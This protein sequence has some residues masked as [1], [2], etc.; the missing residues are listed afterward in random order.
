[1]SFLTIAQ[2]V[3]DIL[4]ADFVV[5]STYIENRTKVWQLFFARANDLDPTDEAAIF[6]PNKWNNEWTVLLAYSVSYDIYVRILSGKFL[7]ISNTS[8]EVDE[9]TGESN[10]TGNIKKIVTGPTEVEYHNDSEALSAV[11][12]TLMGEGGP[13]E[14]FMVLACGFASQIGVKVP[15]C[16]GNRAP[17]GLLI[18]K[19]A[20]KGKRYY[21]YITKKVYGYNKPASVG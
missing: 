6:D 14:Q 16:R 15:Y 11:L 9:T 10:A 2:L 3:E 7:A 4:P 18:G 17:S 21:D 20:I 19:K 8:T 1:M 5:G 12:K 13:Y